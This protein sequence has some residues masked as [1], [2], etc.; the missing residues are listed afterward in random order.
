[1][2]INGNR[3]YCPTLG[4]IGTFTGSIATVE[5]GE[6]DVTIE[7]TM[8]TARS[9]ISF[10]GIVFRYSDNNNFLLARYSWQNV[11]VQF[12]TMV[13]GSFIAAVD[14]AGI[15]PPEAHDGMVM[16]LV[17][18]GDSIELFIDDV[19]YIVRTDS[20]NQTATRHGIVIG[21][22]VDTTVSRLEDFSIS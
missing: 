10:D 18:S 7:I 13:G 19:S 8:P 3:A 9:A 11:R 12:D 14:S 1:M 16:K 22:N 5:S 21:N 17:L 20:F 15:S 4:S 2:G 6:S